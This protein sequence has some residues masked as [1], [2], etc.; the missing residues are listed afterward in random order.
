MDVGFSHDGR[1]SPAR[2]FPNFTQ[3]EPSERRTFLR[4]YVTNRPRTWSVLINRINQ[5]SKDFSALDLLDTCSV[6]LRVTQ[7]FATKGFILHGETPVVYNQSQEKDTRMVEKSESRVEPKVTPHNGITRVYQ[8]DNV[9]ENPHEFI[10][11]YKGRKYD[12]QNLLKK[13][14]GGSRIMKPYKGLN[15]DEAMVT[16]SHSIAAF[17]LFEEFV[18]SNQ[19]EYQEIE[20]LVDWNAPLLSQVGS[21]GDRYWEWVNLPVNRPIRLFA[22]NGLER[23]TVTPWYMVPAV[24]IPIIFFLLY[25]GCSI[26]LKGNFVDS[27]PQISFAISWGILLW[28]FL[29]YTLHRKLFHMKPPADSKIFIT[30]HFLLHGLHHKAPFDE[31]RLVFPPV[32][33]MLLAVVFYTAYEMVFPVAMMNFAA[34]GVAIGYLCYDM[35]HYYLHYGSPK[36]ET[37]MYV[38]KRYHNYHH[39]SYHDE[40]FGISSRLWDYVFG[41]AITLRNLKKAIEW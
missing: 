20:R 29:E 28:T 30:L 38:M 6:L 18:Q 4:Y 7:D 15:V 3:S 2:Q 17:H 9:T 39:F 36:A 25:R 8:A 23:L 27:I 24:W 14:P 34:G 11:K 32:P 22:S 26:D 40:G 35:T 37:Y 12:I 10:V 19:E 31:Q 41:T 13:H 5:F 33:A 21:L 16:N 1:L